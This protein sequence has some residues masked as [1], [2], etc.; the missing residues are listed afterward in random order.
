MGI[1]LGPSIVKG[2]EVIALLNGDEIFPAMLRDIRGARKTIT[3]ETYIYWSG[4][5]GQKFANALAERSRAGIKVHVLVDWAGSDKLDDAL[6]KE[7]KQAGVAFQKFRPLRWYNLGR[8]NNRTHRKLMVV[9]GRV[10]FT[11]GVG[12]ADIWTGHAQDSAHWRDSHFR[13]EGP[14]VAQMQA[15]FMDNWIVATGEVLH[16]DAYFPPLAPTGKLPAQLFF[17]SPSEGSES[18]A[19]MYLL[20]IMAAEQSIYLSS[21]YF[22]PDKLT[23]DALTAARKR[24]VKVQIITPGKYLDT[25]IVRGASRSSWG[26]LLGAGVEIYEYEPSMYHCKVFIVDE[27]LVS[28]GSTNWDPRSFRLNDEANLNIYDAEFARKQVEV[29]RQDLT[30]SRQI[31]LQQWRARPLREKVGEML[32]SVVRGVL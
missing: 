11:G 31:T 20:A 27:L 5:I 25:K 13:V 21:A 24:G 3:L 4:Q 17:S 15:A 14:V 30:K 16:G 7:M 2:N 6:V 12:I 28:V 10:G 32:A 19:L 1:A 18:M 23:Q 8:V 9:D 22:V 29:F 26:D